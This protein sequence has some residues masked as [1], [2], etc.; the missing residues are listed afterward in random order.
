MSRRGVSTGSVEGV[1][2]V[3]NETGAQLERAA[4]A[5]RRRLAAPPPDPLPFPPPRRHTSHALAAETD[6]LYFV[7]ITIFKGSVAER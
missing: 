1:C 3:V 4:A 5:L 7:S 6:P 2:C